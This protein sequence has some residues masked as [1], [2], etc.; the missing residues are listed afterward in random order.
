MN[1]LSSRM[2]ALRTEIKITQVFI[3]LLYFI[4]GFLFHKNH[5][6]GKIYP[7]PQAIN[8]KRKKIKRILQGPSMQDWKN[9]SIKV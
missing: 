7:L 4:A 5:S 1:I 6:E 9:Y 3:F 8:T 2:I